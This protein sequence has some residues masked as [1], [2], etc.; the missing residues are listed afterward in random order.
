[1]LREIHR[2]HVLQALAEYDEIG[3]EGFLDRYGYGKS[4]TYVLVHEGNRYDSK[5]IVGVA[6]RF[7]APGSGALRASE[8]SGG[9]DTVARVLRGLGFEVI[10]TI[11]SRSG[12]TAE[13]RLLALDLYFKIG[14]TSSTNPQ[15]VG[16][17][18]E[19]NARAFHPDAGSRSDFRN[20]N[21]VNLKLANFASLDPSYRGKGM[22]ATSIGDEQT[23]DLYAGDLD[24]LAHAVRAIRDG[25]WAGSTAGSGRPAIEKGPLEDQH[26]EN[27]E[28]TGSPSAT[29]QRTEAALVKA[30]GEW[31]AGLGRTITSHRYHVVSPPLRADLVDDTDQRI[32]E[33]KSSPSRSS[34]RMAIGQLADY[35]RLEPDPHSIGVLLPTA[36]SAD[37]LELI[38]SA[39]A[40]AAW[41]SG[42]PEAPFAV[43][44][45]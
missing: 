31:L 29:G 24:L 8:F 23:W 14:V 41:Y 42:D 18:G 7:I 45:H 13:E 28:V 19:L 36:P 32:W 1:M 10:E 44:E 25:S 39:G 5:A 11:P 37:L 43:L 17:S 30:F 4:R 27:Y 21:G 38:A 35:R 20:P 22:A 12:W 34:I 2:A 3:R 33:A 9:V 6:H 26:V 40:A 15:V 16:L